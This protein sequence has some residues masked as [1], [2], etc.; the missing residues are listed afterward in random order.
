MCD[1]YCDNDK[2]HQPRYYVNAEQ[3]SWSQAID[4]CTK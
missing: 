3:G 4:I 1:F 2:K